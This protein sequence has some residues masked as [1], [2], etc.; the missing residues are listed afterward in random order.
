MKIKLALLG[1]VVFLIGL[2]FLPFDYQDSALVRAMF[3]AGHFPLMAVITAAAYVILRPSDLAHELQL[4]RAAFLGGSIALGIELIQPLF[5][6]TRSLLDL[7]IGVIGVIAAIV[8]IQMWRR[9]SSPLLGAGFGLVLLAICA[10][11]L[12]PA[13]LEWRTHSWMRDKFPML[14]DFESDREMGFWYA[15]GSE[16]MDPELAPSSERATSGRRSLRVRT[17]GNGW[18]SVGYEVAAGDW[19]RIDAVAVDIYNPGELTKL[20]VGILDR[21]KAKFQRWFPVSEGWNRIRVS[22]DELSGL[23]LGSIRHVRFSTDSRAPTRV[24]FVDNLRV[25]L[26]R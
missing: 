16:R 11:A 19:R 24:Y 23:A 17:A 5:G 7:K 26:A 20:R 13:W 15:Y 2:T 9:K 3:D 1:A 14:A 18:N 8:G 4:A 12:R 21:H 6:R 25:I 22:A 10:W